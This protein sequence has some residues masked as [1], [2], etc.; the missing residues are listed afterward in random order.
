VLRTSGEP[1]E[2]NR[3]QQKG[4]MGMKKTQ[5]VVLVGIAITIY[6]TMA[7]AQPRCPLP[8]RVT[9]A[10]N[11]LEV[12]IWTSISVTFSN[13]ITR[14]PMNVSS[15]RVFKQDTDGMVEMVDGTV[16]LDS[17]NLTLTFTPVNQLEPMMQYQ[18]AVFPDVRDTAC[19]PK[20]YSG[21][22]WSF[23][24]GEEDQEEGQPPTIIAASFSGGGW[25]SVFS[26]IVNPNGTDTFVYLDIG[27]PFPYAD[28]WDLVGL[29][30]DGDDDVEVDLALWGC[31][32]A[33]G[34]GRFVA[35]NKYGETYSDY[36][37]YQ[38]PQ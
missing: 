26:V 36:F 14:S 8:V 7:H 34:T 29:A 28:P 16:E 12:D 27:Y 10:D 17:N 21:K 25:D 1:P 13:P 4:R 20:N 32:V 9:P 19:N 38:Y 5:M 31:D 6:C 37:F 23:Q 15:L 2:R 18:A 3:R 30:G 24:T 35:V 11:S 33:G 22:I